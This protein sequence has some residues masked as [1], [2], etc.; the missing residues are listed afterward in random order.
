MNI[1]IVVSSLVGLI[2]VALRS[3]LHQRNILLDTDVCNPEHG[4]VSLRNAARDEFIKFVKD[5]YEG[6]YAIESRV[7]SGMPSIGVFCRMDIGLIVAKNQVYYFVNELERVQTTSLWSNK[8]TK[9]KSSRARI[10]VFGTTFSET[11]HD[12]LSH[13]MSPYRA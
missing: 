6:L 4:S 3:V 5:T 7:L 11:F 9:E 2:D 8:P 1:K 13:T 10:G 12:W